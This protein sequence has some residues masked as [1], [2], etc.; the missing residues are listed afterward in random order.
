[1]TA[2]NFDPPVEVE[3]P[4]GVG[5]IRS[6]EEGLDWVEELLADDYPPALTRALGHAEKRLRLAVG[7]QSPAIVGRVTLPGRVPGSGVGASC[8]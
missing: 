1:M 5:L 8:H 4:Q 6:V 3:T 2:T 7:S